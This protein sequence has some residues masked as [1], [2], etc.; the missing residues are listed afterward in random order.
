MNKKLLHI[1]I[2]LLVVIG[3]AAVMAF[4][5]LTSEFPELA[6]F[7]AMLFAVMAGGVM[8][9]GAQFQPDLQYYTPLLAW[10]GTTRQII[11]RRFVWGAA[12]AVSLLMPMAF[13]TLS[14]IF[15]R[16]FVQWMWEWSWLWSLGV[17]P[18]LVT[19]ALIADTYVRRQSVTATVDASAPAA[20]APARRTRMRTLVITFVVVIVAQLLMQV[21]ARTI[22]ITGMLP[23][24]CFV[25][26]IVSLFTGIFYR[27]FERWTPYPEPRPPESMVQRQRWLLIVSGV[28][29]P[30]IGTAMMT[31]LIPVE[32]RLRWLMIPAVL[33]LLFMV[34]DNW[35][36]RIGV[37]RDKWKA[38]L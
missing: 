25:L 21:G 14:P 30:A 6:R 29:F 5:T 23:I 4:F 3:P 2:L 7:A 38:S 12:G 22:G 31:G 9:M 37:L 15:G 19:G 17:P 35:S 1:V 36:W 32:Y 13:I 16:A 26:G 24:A 34:V 33:F 27:Q 20:D 10:Q 28:V 11:V 8:A 18:L